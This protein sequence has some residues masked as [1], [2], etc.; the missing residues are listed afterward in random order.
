MMVQPCHMHALKLLQGAPRARGR[1]LSLAASLRG[2][3]DVER[4]RTLLG[5]PWPQVL[6]SPLHRRV[7]GDLISMAEKQKARPDGEPK[8]SAKGRQ[9]QFGAV[10]HNFLWQG[11]FIRRSV[12]PNPSGSRARD[13]SGHYATAPALFSKGKSV[14]RTRSR[15]APRTR[16]L[17][18]IA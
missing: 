15:M 9:L 17:V 6:V 3:V 16:G 12:P 2:E 11:F 18:C 5:L 10:M 1:I 13:P 8:C 4:L 7:D 14:Q